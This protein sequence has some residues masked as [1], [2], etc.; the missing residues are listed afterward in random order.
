MQITLL[1][2]IAAF[3]LSLMITPLARRLAVRYK[4]FASSNHRTIHQGSMPKLGGLGIFLAFLTGF[5]IYAGATHK[6]DQFA[7][8]ILGSSAVLAV[9]LIDDI[10]HLSCYRKLCGQ[11]L[12]AVIAV[13]AGFKLQVVYLP[14]AVV[15]D[16]GIWSAPLS[17][18]WIVSIT[19]AV[20]LLDGLD[21]LASGFTVITALFVLFSAVIFQNLEIAALAVILIAA[22]LGF[23]K[24]NFNP[25][26]IF[27]G[28]MG[29]LFLGFVLA[30]LSM[31]AF[32]TTAGGTHLS[33]LLVLF[34]IP[35]TDTLLAVVRRVMSG[36]SPFTADKKHL[37]HRM[38]AA[39]MSQTATVLMV[40]SATFVCGVLSLVLY[41]A[42]VQL[43]VIMISG[44]LL[45]NLL[46]L[47]QLGSFDFLSRKEYSRELS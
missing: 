21:G 19:N 39:G 27:M 2:V 36:R 20:N 43:A 15:L 13:F 40:Y 33:P 6:I 10:M 25:A 23:L 9:G 18:L 5:L 44:I 38:L 41:M 7:G 12:A 14:F 11:I 3:V 30:C 47:V 45:L 1:S 46:A 35:L 42:D 31:Q 37:H 17:V 22:T 4:I 26:K 24:Y 32:T 8:F 34:L 16:L 29:S 28:D